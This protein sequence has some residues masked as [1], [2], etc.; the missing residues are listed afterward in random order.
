MANRKHNGRWPNNTIREFSMTG[1]HFKVSG[2]YNIVVKKQDGTEIETGWFPNLILDQGLNLMGGT[3]NSP[4]YYCSVGTGT[5]T[6]VVTQT[7]LDSVLAYSSYSASSSTVNSGAPTYAGLHTHVYSFT[8]G[9]VV[10]NITEIGIGYNNTNGTL[11]SRA[12]ILDSLGNPTSITLIALDQLIVYYRLTLTPP[13]TDTTGSVVL[14]GTTYNFTS[15]L[16]NANNW[17]SIEYVYEYSQYFNSI[18]SVTAYGSDAALAPVTSYS[19]SGT[20][21]GAGNVST[22]T[23][24]TNNFYIDWNIGYP[25]SSGNAT[26]GIKGF[27]IIGGGP[28]NVMNYQ[29][30]LDAAIPKVNTNQL[31]LTFRFSWGR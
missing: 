13:L 12:L 17:G 14:N 26:G 24:T 1:F 20:S 16:C 10:G 31:S 25:P 11:F 28:W 6:P 3:A 18:Y 21:V 29:V 22:G 23:Y 8:Q 5:S 19:C 27:R 7:S 15:R 4:L 9:S 2:E 30:V